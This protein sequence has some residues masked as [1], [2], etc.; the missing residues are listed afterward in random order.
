[1]LALATR[2]EVGRRYAGQR[3][4]VVGPDALTMRDFYSELRRA[5]GLSAPA[6]FL[7]VPM[8]AMRLVAA[9]GKWLPDSPLDPDTLAMLERGNTAAAADTEA[10]LG[11]S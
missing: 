7:P 8:A 9:A 2:A 1:I 10:I 4:A 6:R 5:M 3:V 11:R